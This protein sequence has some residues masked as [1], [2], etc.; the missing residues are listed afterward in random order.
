MP[1]ATTYILAVHEYI[2]RY[3]V[4]MNRVCATHEKVSI[5]YSNHPLTTFSLERHHRDGPAAA[6][7]CQT[8]VASQART[9]CTVAR[10][11]YSVGTL[12]L[13]LQ[14]TGYTYRPF[15]PSHPPMSPPKAPPDPSVPR[16]VT[17]SGAHPY[18]M[19]LVRLGAGWLFCSW[20]QRCLGPR[21][22][23][24]LASFDG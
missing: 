20:P 1:W 2:P 16:R 7:V 9:K 19:L 17:R 22:L 15:L 23:T 6:T 13:G 5:E 24:S 10:D 8:V 14:A 21:D 11:C 18:S 3:E 4:C 12:A